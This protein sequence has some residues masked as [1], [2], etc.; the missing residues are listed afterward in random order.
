MKSKRYNN[1]KDIA[2][3]LGLDPKLGELAELKAKL[4]LEIIK[5]IENKGLTHKEVAELSGIPRSA[6]TGIVNGSLQK[7]SMDRLMR[8]LFALGNKVSVKVRNVA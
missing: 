1:M 6:V 8:V 7:V 3:D 2:K 5:A 4:T